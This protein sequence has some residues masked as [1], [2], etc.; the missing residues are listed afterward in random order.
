MPWSEIFIKKYQN[1][2]SWDNLIGYNESIP[3]SITFIKEYFIKLGWQEGFIKGLWENCRPDI[4][5]KMIE[6][7]MAKIY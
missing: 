3:W 2:W 6:E 7:I 1:K 5:D 4:D